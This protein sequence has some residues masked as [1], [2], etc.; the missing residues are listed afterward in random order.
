MGGDL[1]TWTPRHF[2]VPFGVRTMAAALALASSRETCVSSCWL[3]FAGPSIVRSSKDACSSARHWLQR[4][5]ESGFSRPHEGHFMVGA[6]QS[7][8]GNRIILYGLQAH[9]RILRASVSLRSPPVAC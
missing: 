2:E 9:K 6:C 8:A 5:A 3:G 7:V 4:T 1:A